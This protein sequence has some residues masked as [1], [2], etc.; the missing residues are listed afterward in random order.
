MRYGA[1]TPASHVE[2]YYRNAANHSLAEMRF[3]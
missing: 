3:I 1:R 2:K